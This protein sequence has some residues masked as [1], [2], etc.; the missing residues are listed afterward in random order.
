M[1]TTMTPFCASRF[2]QYKGIEAD[3]L[4]YPPPEFHNVIGA[5]SLILHNFEI[6]KPASTKIPLASIVVARVPVYF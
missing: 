5:L 1:M 3:S 4:M 2:P 6:H